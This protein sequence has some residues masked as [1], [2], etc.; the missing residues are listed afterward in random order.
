MQKQNIFCST[1]GKKWLVA[2]TGLF[3]VFFVVVHLL[4]NLGIFSGPEATNKYAAF[5][6]SIPMLLWGFRCALIVSVVVHVWLTIDL[7]RLNRRARPEFYADK[8]NRKANF[9]SRYMLWSGLT[10]LMFVCYH[11][12]HY[13]LG[14]TNP[15]YFD[16]HDQEGRHHVYNM[17][18]MGFSNPFISAFYIVAQGLLAMHLSHGISSAARTLGVGDRHLFRRIQTGGKILSAVIA[19]LF[20]SI[21]V[22]VLLG[23]LPLAH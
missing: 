16:L 17:M 21:P 8:K 13:T 18:V 23:Y 3:M 2:I 4:G 20:I 6:K 7:T 14:V 9:S 5:L 15:E 19:I 22:A 11:L 12:A 1:I 10:V